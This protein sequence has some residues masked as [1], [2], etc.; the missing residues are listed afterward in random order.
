MIHSVHHINF[1]VRDLDAAV[2]KYERLLDRTVDSRDVLPDRGVNIARFNLGGTWIVLVQTTR[3]G[4][5]SARHLEQHGE[6]FFLMSLEVDSLENEA[7]RLG[8]DAFATPS[9]TGL[10]D[11]VVRD[12][13]AVETC[14][15]QLQYVATKSRKPDE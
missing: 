2:A 10:E 7:Q 11:W 1:L 6:G 13:D 4:T 8:D 12:L 3:S 15:A 5:T 9:R 14:G